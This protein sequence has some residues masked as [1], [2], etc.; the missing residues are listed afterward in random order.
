MFATKVTPSYAVFPQNAFT[1][2]SLSTLLTDQSGCI[3]PWDVATYT[4]VLFRFKSNPNV[5]SV[6]DIRAP[7][8]RTALNSFIQGRLRILFDLCIMGSHTETTLHSTVGRRGERGG[9]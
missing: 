6:Y 2:A 7:G 1:T 8:T 5:Y 9:L 4:Q 3:P